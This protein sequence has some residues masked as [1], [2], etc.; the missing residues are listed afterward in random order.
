MPDRYDD[1]LLL[2][3]VEGDLSEEDRKAFERE[4]RADDSLRQ[5]LDGIMDDRK[6][7]RDMPVEQAPDD[8]MER[9]NL[10]LEREALLA[11]SP[12]DDEAT[13]DDAP[14]P[15]FSFSRFVAYSGVAAM[16]LLCGTLVFQAFQDAGRIQKMVDETADAK[17]SKPSGTLALAGPQKKA[18]LGVG[19]NPAD[20]S[21]G[22]AIGGGGGGGGGGFNGN[23]GKISGKSQPFAPVPPSV[24]VE[25]TRGKP[26]E[27]QQ[28]NVAERIAPKENRAAGKALGLEE[29][30]LPKPKVAEVL[31]LARVGGKNATP[32]ESHLAFKQSKAKEQLAAVVQND[33]LELGQDDQFAL[34]TRQPNA[35]YL[36]AS[37]RL[38]EHVN[39]NKSVDLESR[40]AVGD[41]PATT[42]E[43]PNAE[44][45]IDRAKAPTA[46]DI[47]RIRR[48]ATGDEAETERSKASEE[49]IATD[50]LRLEVV[51]TKLG[52]SEKELLAW[53]QGNQITVAMAQVEGNSKYSNLDRYK[54][55]PQNPN[56]L[57]DGI[58]G[59]DDG[60]ALEI[61]REGANKKSVRPSV[62]PSAPVEPASNKSRAKA[63]AA[64]DED[65]A[66]D[67]VAAAPAPTIDPKLAKDD[68]KPKPETEKPAAAATKR[69]GEGADPFFGDSP[70]ARP[71]ELAKKL[72]DARAH[73]SNVRLREY[74]I[75]VRADQIPQLV[76]HLNRR[77]AQHAKLRGAQQLLVES[78]SQNRHEAVAVEAKQEKEK[79]EELHR[80][81]TR[82]KRKSTSSKTRAIEQNMKSKREADK[83]VD[84]RENAAST[85]GL[86]N[87][88]WGIILNEQL[89]LTQKPLINFA[90]AD[91]ILSITIREID[92]PAPAAK[93]TATKGRANP[94]DAETDVKAKKN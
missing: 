93:V 13:Y 27:S 82:A 68:P 33:R 79:E 22:E 44:K 48:S 59:A 55:T 52:D 8:L 12:E 10:S 42:D 23:T 26:N 90:N 38:A 84:A 75:R 81:Q 34:L 63:D 20:D 64:A 2:D 87:V 83:A 71:L 56:P 17:D 57:A 89:P 70:N 91:I 28:G 18:D 19:E 15:V 45:K 1:Q 67:P 54:S 4:V 47:Y 65:S 66:K 58:T 50:P 62:A 5:L 7:L 40:D 21:A 25:T 14:P 29:K 16:I 94:A 43:L 51:S 86:D 37:R 61:A 9:V 85:Y 76:A 80:L 77:G 74:T 32:E 73:E 88:D 92:E 46:A 39:E 69:G 49:A 41:K 30:S 24:A 36:P 60:G 78:E 72:K 31:D 6:Q 11:E 3:Y 53:A 35:D